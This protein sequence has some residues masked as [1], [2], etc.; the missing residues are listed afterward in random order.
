MIK[1]LLNQIKVQKNINYIM[2]NLFISYSHKDESI[3]SE[4]IKHLSPLKSNGIVEEWFDRKIMS[5]DDF[6]E[7][8]DKEL[9]SADVICLMISHNFL[10]SKACLKEKD[11]SLKLKL[12][13]GIRV[14]PVILSPC[15]WTEHKEISELLATPT[16]GKPI[17]SFTDINEGILNAINWIKTVCISITQIKNL[18]LKNEFNVFLESADIL[19]KSHNNK[20][21]LL[22]SD[23]FVYP[24]LKKI[25]GVEAIKKYDS[26][27]LRHDIL[28][29]KKIIISGE[30]QSGKT[31]LC[32]VVYKIFIELNHIPVYIEDDNKFLGNPISKIENAFNEQY[33]NA[34]YDD[35]D[36]SRIVPIID[37]FHYAKHQEKYIEVY[38][39]FKYQVLIVDDIY[40]LNIQKQNL[41]KDYNKFKI[42]EFN[43]I[44]RDL[45]I[46][47]WILITE[48]D[49]I[50]INQNHFQQSV[51][52]KTE[53][54][55]NSL[56]VIFG[57]GI[58]PSFPFFILS[59]LAAQ[60]I[61]KPLDQEITSQGHCYQA[62]IYLYLRKEGVRNDQFDI[63]SN[64]LT[65]LSFFI[66]ENGGNSLDNS[67]FNEFLKIYTTRFNM[68]IPIADVL[69]KLSNVSICRFDSLNQFSFCYTYIYYFF[70]AKYISENIEEKKTVLNNI[71]SNLHTD[72]NA[73][74]TVFIAH[75]SKSNYLLDELLLNAEIQFEKYNPSTLDK[76]EL[77][78]FDK[79]EEKIV[80]AILPA[81]DHNCTE[82]R[83]KILELK[84]EFEENKTE[85]NAIEESN[86][87]KENVSEEEANELLHDLRL[88]IKTVEV[89]GLIIK[90]R[91]GS[92][93]LDKL[94]YIFE[95]GLKVHLRILT[96]FFELI[97]DEQ[98]EIEFIEFIN[99][100]ICQI[101]EERIENNEKE[102][103]IEKIEKISKDI[104]WNMSFGVVHGF[105]T[106]A[107]H[108]LGSSNLLKIAEN[109]SIKQNTP[110]SFIVYQGI[111][112][113]Y[114]KSIKLNE[115]SAR[116]SKDDFSKTADKLIKFKV[117]EHSRLHKIEYGKLQEIG[118][119]LNMSIDRLLADRALNK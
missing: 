69:T 95:Q 59:L 23:I 53:M 36:K 50:R 66:Y 105:I 6:Q 4:F 8:I 13:K 103:S 29:L 91:S 75:H 54:I 109:V 98:T 97:K 22:L 16:D 30:N 27:K 49:L 74:I 1:H 67:K 83:A 39:I 81:F 101:N 112:M 111:N 94:E 86:A 115:I 85:K 52:E 7:S 96:S 99:E 14:I 57:K 3:V 84:S 116:I 45:L 5:G 113:W 40:G 33:E 35:V 77:S 9:E 17:S 10:S 34:T 18:R 63:Y 72:E 61:Q 118:D 38:K 110:S 11:N 44:E 68:P 24:K 20:E 104:F 64:F 15:A 31:T 80:K 108:S 12:S 41:I 93:G 37:N 28:E 43:A 90:N 55:E 92:L 65:E 32:K 78:F 51:D 117:V 82:E 47:K 79:N 48:N 56:G 119:K 21:T 46:R 26:E 62:L 42:N 2:K 60:D 76:N 70:V 100:R 106:K 87:Q 58:M 114:G 89:M 71:I 25:N 107:I 73:Y 88:S 19:T 102:L